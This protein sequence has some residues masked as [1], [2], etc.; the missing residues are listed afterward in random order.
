M[1]L[2]EMLKMPMQRKKSEKSVMLYAVDI[3]RVLCGP[4]DKE[5]IADISQSG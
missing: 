1:L 4:R 3:E 5:N 2:C